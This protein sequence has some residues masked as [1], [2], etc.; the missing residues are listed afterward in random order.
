MKF[1]CMFVCTVYTYSLEKVYNLI[2][3]T[4]LYLT[5]MGSNNSN[6]GTKKTLKLQPNIYK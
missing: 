4:G 1:A 5:M 6:T 3:M 2:C